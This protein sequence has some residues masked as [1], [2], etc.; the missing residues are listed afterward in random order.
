[1]IGKYLYSPSGKILMS[2]HK[3]RIV[4]LTWYTVTDSDFSTN[5]NTRLAGLTATEPNIKIPSHVKSGSITN[6]LWNCSN[7]NTVYI[8]F[9]DDSDFE[10]NRFD[11]ANTDTTKQGA[12]KEISNLPDSVR[13]MSVSAPNIKK[14]SNVGRLTSFT[15]KYNTAMTNLNG[16]VGLS[17]NDNITT[18]KIQEN[19]GLVDL[20]DFIIPENVSVLNAMFQG[21][22]ALEKA[23]IDY[24]YTSSILSNSGLMF[25]RTAI[26]HLDI[27]AS[28]LQSMTM[29]SGCGF[30]QGA[31]EIRCTPNTNT[32]T[33][34]KNYME[35]DSTPFSRSY[36]G[37]RRFCLHSFAQNQKTITIWGDS[38]TRGG[39]GTTYSDLC[40]KLSDM[41]SSDSVVQNLGAGGTSAVNQASYFNAYD[42]G[43]N[44]I[45]VLFFG[46]N[47]PD[48]T[49]QSY[50]ESY[51]PHLSKYIVLG[52]VTKN[53][54]TAMNNQMAEEYGDHFVDTHAYMVANGF[55]ITGLTPTAQDEEDL[56]NGNVPHSFLA[57]DYIHINEYGGLIVAT[58]IKEKLLSLGYIDNTWLA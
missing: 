54:S 52:L 21:C 49:I 13:T 39:D 35:A 42:V 6:Q 34:W 11:V 5:Y 23:R 3:Y 32:W 9:T 51:I 17:D 30:T 12:L 31:V 15:F 2:R 7:S 4:P 33:F 38:L 45:T 20:S 41:L 37:A 25:Q 26:K 55:A 29:F 53:Y 24:N 18:L 10:L 46:H 40:V 43:W 28:D 16:I 47:S 44:D 1:M 14:I 27:Y 57:S 19:T 58:A 22:S 36:S 8:T 48:T 56:T 50:N